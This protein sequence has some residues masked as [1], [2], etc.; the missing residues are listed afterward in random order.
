MKEFEDLHVIE[1]FR[2]ILIYQ[3]G[4]KQEFTDYFNKKDAI[5]F[6]EKNKK[7]NC[8]VESYLLEFVGLVPY[9][10]GNIIA[11]DEDLDD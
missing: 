9:D 8:E 6:G 10:Q 1:V 2:V 5:A 3:N 11:N 7:E 4:W